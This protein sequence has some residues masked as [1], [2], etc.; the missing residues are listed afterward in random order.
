[1]DVMPGGTSLVLYALTAVCA[2]ALATVWHLTNR[3]RRNAGFATKA[4]LKRHLSARAVL[5]ATEI[6]PSL[7]Q[8]GDQLTR[9]PAVD[10]TKNRSAER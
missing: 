5:K 6:R 8:S 7:T 10:L 2:V 9:I 3:A 1:M 4:Q